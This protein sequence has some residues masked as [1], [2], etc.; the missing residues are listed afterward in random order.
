MDQS[1]KPDQW[2]RIFDVSDPQKHEK[3]Y[4]IYKISSTVSTFIV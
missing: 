4:T 1:N 3:G 2:A